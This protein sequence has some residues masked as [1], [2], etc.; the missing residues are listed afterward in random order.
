M[1]DQISKIQDIPIDHRLINSLLDKMQLSKLN[2]YLSEV[3]NNESIIMMRKVG[4]FP[5]PKRFL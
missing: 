3:I 4:L 2:S 5:I 1:R